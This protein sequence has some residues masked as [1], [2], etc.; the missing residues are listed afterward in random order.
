MQQERKV[1]G[2]EDLVLLSQVDEPSIVSNLDKRFAKNEIY[3]SIGNVLVS[4]NPFRPV[5]LYEPE[6]I[7]M[8]ENGV[9]SELP[10]HVYAVAESAFRTMISVS[11]LNYQK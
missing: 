3:T 2:L 6:H 9:L 10:P 7:K 4:C 5:N 8:Y 1:V 11:C